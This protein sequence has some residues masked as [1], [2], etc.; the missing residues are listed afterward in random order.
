V[1]QQLKVFVNLIEW[2]L[3]TDV[4]S[5]RVLDPKYSDPALFGSGSRPDPKILN[6][7]GSG[8]TDFVR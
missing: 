3:L 2:N 4:L 6:P 1:I 7:A 8:F 5:R